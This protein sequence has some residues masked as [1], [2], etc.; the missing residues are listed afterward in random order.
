MPSFFLLI[1]CSACPVWKNG[2]L[3]CTSGKGAPSPSHLVAPLPASGAQPWPHS[4]QITGLWGWA[5]WLPTELPPDSDATRGERPSQRQRQAIVLSSRVLSQPKTFRSA[6]KCCRGMSQ[7]WVREA[8]AG[9]GAGDRLMQRERAPLQLTWASACF[10]R[11]DPARC[12]GACVRAP[13]LRDGGLPWSPS[14][15]HF[16]SFCPHVP[17]CPRFVLGSP[18]SVPHMA[19]F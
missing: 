16:P 8:T 11:A 15:L 5:V 14:A 19:W 1:F 17:A 6:T 12:P 13:H 4:G 10:S 9:S 3:A 7:H 18:F 2:W